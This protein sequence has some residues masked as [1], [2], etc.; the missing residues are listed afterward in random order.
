M[1]I[2]RLKIPF[3]RVYGT[4]EVL[5]LFVLEP[6]L[7]GHMVHYWLFLEESMYNA[8]INLWYAGSST[9]C[10]ALSLNF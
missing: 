4:E 8:K 5:T 10:P 7:A 1:W 9:T 3:Q 2:S 6:Y